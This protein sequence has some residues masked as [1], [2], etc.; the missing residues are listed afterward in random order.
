MMLLRKVK[1]NIPFIKTIRNKLVT[2]THISKNYLVMTL[3]L[4]LPPK[5]YRATVKFE[6]QVNSEIY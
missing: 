2:V 5:K 6:F 1:M 3:H 4:W